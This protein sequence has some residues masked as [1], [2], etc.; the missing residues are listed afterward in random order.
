MRKMLVELEFGPDC[1][2]DELP[3]YHAFAVPGRD[4]LLVNGERLWG[5]R[6]GQYEEDPEAYALLE[7]RTSEVVLPV[8]GCRVLSVQD[9]AGDWF[10]LA[11]DEEFP[12]GSD[13]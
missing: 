9:D 13:Y 1:R 2:F 8:R 7:V 3:D 6:I 11:A 12:D 10:A 5:V 4:E